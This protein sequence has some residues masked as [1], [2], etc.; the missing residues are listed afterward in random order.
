MLAVEG[1]SKRF[2]GRAVVDDLSFSVPAGRCF[3]LVGPNGAGKSTTIRLL[4]GIMEPSSG[5]IFF[6]GE[7]VR[8]GSPDWK[9]RIGV[10]PD[11]L[12]LFEHLTF[13][14]HL[15]LAG[16]MYGLTERETGG[17]TDDLLDYLGLN[18]AREMPAVEASHGMRRKLAIAL[19][20]IHKPVLLLCDEVFSGLDSTS[21]DRVCGLLKIL[22]GSRAICVLSTHNVRIAE[23]VLDTVGIMKEGVLTEIVEK[24][25]PQAS[26][27]EIYRRSVS[28]SGPAPPELPWL[29]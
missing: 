21:V 18:G 5:Q 7:K 27:E 22:V 12:A 11:D 14:E 16:S 4:A 19:A 1:I 6:H 13:V 26:F 8:T 28:V 23:A 9:G 20:V 3:G 25:G 17:R 24:P 15:H 10:V 2:H 29:G